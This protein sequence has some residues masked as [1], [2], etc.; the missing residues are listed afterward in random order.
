[1]F[2]RIFAA[3]SASSDYIPIRH[4]NRN[5]CHRHLLAQL[6][7]PEP[8]ELPEKGVVQVKHSRSG[9]VQIIAMLKRVKAVWREP[10]HTTALEIKFAKSCNTGA[11]GREVTRSHVSSF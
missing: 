5:R 4:R 2:S 1:M 3:L 9:G 6:M 8:R 7:S 11:G 10:S